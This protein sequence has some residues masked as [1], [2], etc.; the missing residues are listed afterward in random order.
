MCMSELWGVSKEIIEDLAEEL[1]AFQQEFAPLFRTKTRDVSEHGLTGLKGSLGMEGKRSY[2][3]VARQLVDPLDDGQNDQPFLSD[4]PWDSRAVFAGI[5]A[6]IRQTP[7]LGG[8]MLNLDDSGDWCS[9]TN[10]A[11]AQ[12]QY[13]G[14][15]GKVE[16]GQVGVVAA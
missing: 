5:Q 1:L 8:G 11:G 16:V 12:R 9:S 7:G 13:L 15:F 14:R 6:Q 10:K 2:V 3:E 4:A